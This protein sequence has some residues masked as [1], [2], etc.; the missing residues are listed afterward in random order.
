MYAPL[1]T[2]SR[3]NIVEAPLLKPTEEECG[4]FPTSEK[5]AI[6]LSKGIKP[7]QVT[8]PLPE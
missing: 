3:D 2:L 8:G 7:P 4:T 5:E 6:L 1:M